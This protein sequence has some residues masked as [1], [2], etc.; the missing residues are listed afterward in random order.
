MT[1]WHKFDYEDRRNTA[2]VAHET[3]WVV[4]E[5]YING[6]TQGFFDGYTF[7][8]FDS[9]DDCKVSYWAEIEYPEPPEEWLENN[10]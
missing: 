2:P 7:N 4:E 5:F 6:V 8:T 3:V 1:T 10:G 9:K